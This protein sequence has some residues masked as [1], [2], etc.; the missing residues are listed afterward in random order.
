[1]GQ[2]ISSMRFA[3]ELTGEFRDGKPRQRRDGTTA[4]S[5]SFYVGSYHV[6]SGP[7]LELARLRRDATEALARSAE[8]AGKDDYRA[9]YEALSGF[10]ARFSGRQVPADEMSEEMEAAASS[11]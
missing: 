11:R 10:V 1:S 8:A 2:D 9:A 6:L 4:R 5:R 3:I 7:A